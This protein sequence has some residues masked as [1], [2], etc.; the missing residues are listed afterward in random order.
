MLPH[1]FG[2]AGFKPNWSLYYFN[3]GNDIHAFQRRFQILFPLT[4]EQLSHLLRTILNELWPEDD[5]LDRMV[6]RCVPAA[7]SS[8]GAA[9]MI[10]GILE[11]QLCPL[12]TEISLNLL[13]LCAF[14]YRG[15]RL[16]TV[17]RRLEKLCP[18]FQPPPL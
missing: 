1:T 12:H 17:C 5:G 10:T 16:L 9:R 8:I 6:S 13:L 7:I 18:S 2:D 11:L 4:A 15:T 14:I 3:K